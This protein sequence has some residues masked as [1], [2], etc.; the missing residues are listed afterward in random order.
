MGIDEK[1][2]MDAGAKYAGEIAVFA[3]GYVLNVGRNGNWKE[4]MAYNTG[5]LPD[6]TKISKMAAGLSRIVQE[7]Y[8]ESDFIGLTPQEAASRILNDKRIKE[9]T[10]KI[11]GSHREDVLKKARAVMENIHGDLQGRYN[12]KIRTSASSYDH[13]IHAIGQLPVPPGGGMH[14]ISGVMLS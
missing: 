9:H 13:D 10:D 5:L 1:M 7:K 4:R 8:A 6:T 12:E 11:P 14:S 2:V 3:N